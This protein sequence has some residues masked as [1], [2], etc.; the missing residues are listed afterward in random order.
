M[1]PEEAFP[2]P[3][4]RP[5]TMPSVRGH[6][7]EWLDACRG[8]PRPLS[9]FDDSG[10]LME[11]LLLGNVATMFPVVLEYDPRAG[12]I[13]NHNEANAALARRPIREGWEID[14]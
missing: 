12:R 13:V 7:P 11:L 2:E 10:P 14:G 6:M 8:G 5:Q 3:L 9:N 4:G 1:L